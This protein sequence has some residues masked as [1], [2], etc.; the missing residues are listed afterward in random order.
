MMIIHRHDLEER[1]NSSRK[2]VMV[3]GRRKTG[4]SYLVKNFVRYDYYFFVKRDSTII[5]GEQNLDYGAFI[6]ILR[7]L[8]KENKTVVIDEFQRLPAD[9]FDFIHHTEKNGKL[10]VI[11]ST[12]LMARKLV[13]KNSPVLGFFEEI[14]VDLISIGDVLQEL[15]GYHLDNDR[16]LE[17]AIILREPLAIDYF[18]TETNHRDL[19]ERIV[20]GS[21]NSLSSLI[22]E[23]F[24]EEERELSKVYEGVIRAIANGNNSSTEISNSLF[25][26]GLIGKNDPS[27]VQQY[28]NNLRNLGIIR[29]VTIFNR[30]KFSYQLISPLLRL[31]YYADEKYN[32]SEIDNKG[33]VIKKVVDSL[34]P[35]IVEDNVRE[36]IAFNLG[37][38]ETIV[39]ETGYD[40]DGVFLR[41]K[42]PQ[43]TLEVKWTSRVSRE[44]ILKAEA[45]SARFDVKERLLFLKSKNGVE[46]QT[47]MKVIDVTDLF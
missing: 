21:L 24:I 20:T 32:V 33:E 8:M 30:N 40:V 18:D 44:D 45:S 19:I 16:L 4:K 7:I 27:I 36:A 28:L 38:T 17:L 23:I 35:R 6:E 26:Q 37:L 25:S 39:N 1:I 13:D 10:I 22:G 41:F 3:Y 43:A 11:S 12:L 46:N 31:F 14:R 5:N 29:K 9:F 2:W 42:E 47:S 15:R 34:M